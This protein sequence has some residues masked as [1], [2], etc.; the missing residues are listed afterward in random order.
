MTSKKTLKIL[1]LSEILE[2]L[3]IS[4]STLYRKIDNGTF[5]PPI[6]LNERAVGF[7]SGEINKTF[8]AMINGAQTEELKELVKLILNE[9][10]ELEVS[11]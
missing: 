9:R 6:S 8:E 3:A 1:K 4:R 5:P 7:L 10:S 11:L 2:L